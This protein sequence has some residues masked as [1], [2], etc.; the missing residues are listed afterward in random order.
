[1]LQVA[2]KLEY[3]TILLVS[4]KQSEWMFMTN[5]LRFLPS[6]DSVLVD[7]RIQSLVK[8]FSHQTMTGLIRQEIERVRSNVAGGGEVPPFDVLV[9]AIVRRVDDLRQPGLRP[10][11]NATGVILHTNL[12]RAPLSREAIEDMK[13]VATGYSNL[14]FDLPAGERGSRQVHGKELLCQVTGAEAALVVNNNASA[15]LL[16]LTALAKGKEVVVSRGQAVEIGGGFRIPDVLRQSGARLVEVGTTNRTYVAD[17][18]Q[19][20]NDHTGA[21]LRVHTSNFRIVGFAQEVGLSELVELG[22]R[23]GIPVID[24]LGS[25]CLLDTRQFGLGPEPMVQESVRLGAGLVCFSGDKLLGGPQAGIVVGRKTLVDKMKR[26][27]LSRAV[28][29]DKLS[30]AALLV[31]LI[32]YLEGEAIEKIPVWRMIAAPIEAL[33]G[34]AQKWAETVGFG[35][36]VIDGQSTVGGGSLP[37]ETLSTKLAAIPPPRSN[38]KKDQKAL[39]E[40]ARRLRLND[41]PVIGRL[42]KNAL[43]LDPRTVLPEE[44]EL[45]LKS[46]LEAIGRT[47]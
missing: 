23:L 47:N 24:D 39:V 37:G 15:V 27:P 3:V 10:V 9:E 30:L 17:Y 18:E 35:A 41:P 34:R 5:P 28:R 13:R 26:H 42:E 1:M 32:H 21:L 14:E 46:L 20:I 44:D 31:T 8:V 45:L 33:E 7:E 11:I 25:G 12:G 6:V 2:Q 19:A 29:I 36:R 22:S 16:A 38:G 4:Q 43:L 40:M